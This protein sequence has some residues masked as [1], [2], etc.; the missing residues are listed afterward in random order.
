MRTLTYHPMTHNDDGTRTVH[1][2]AYGVGAPN[3][4]RTVCGL[5]VG[6]CASHVKATDVHCEGCHTLD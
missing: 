1:V 3:P 4:D 2:F 6:Q 5:N